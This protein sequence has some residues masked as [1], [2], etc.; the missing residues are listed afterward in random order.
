M[1]SSA[2]SSHRERLHYRAKRH[3]Q[4]PEEQSLKA[5]HAV[6][7]RLLGAN[8]LT[9]ARILFHGSSYRPFPL[10]TVIVTV[11]P[12][13]GSRIVSVMGASRHSEPEARP[14][15]SSRLVQQRYNLAGLVNRAFNAL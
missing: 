9:A 12:V 1:A 11:W 7:A 10:G 13:S 15:R 14:S 6:C 2:T 5:P 8:A 4:R 3:D